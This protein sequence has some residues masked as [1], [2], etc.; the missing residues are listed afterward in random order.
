MRYFELRLSLDMVERDRVKL[1]REMK[2]RIYGQSMLNLED[3]VKSQ[4]IC[5]TTEILMVGYIHT[6]MAYRPLY[7]LNSSAELSTIPSL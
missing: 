1:F 3:N 6:E 5:R 7:C 2:G 4:V